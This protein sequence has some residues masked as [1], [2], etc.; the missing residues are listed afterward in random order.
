[1][2]QLPERS[3]GGEANHQGRHLFQMILAIL[4]EMGWIAVDP[5]TTDPV[6]ELPHHQRG[7]LVPAPGL[8]STQTRVGQTLYRTPLMAD[9]LLF[10]PGWEMP[11]GLFGKHQAGSGSAREKLPY[12]YASIF[13]GALCPCAVLLDGPELLET[14]VIAY[15]RE[16]AEKS[17][18]RI[19]SVLAGVYEFGQWARNG[20]P[21]PKPP[22]A[23]LL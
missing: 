9:F 16:F 5:R 20:F 7:L 18:G 23:R 19:V 11:I 3:Q 10:S 8:F 22:E 12:L 2:S 6:R 21:Y 4:N 1:M 15:A 13:K 14:P 17:G